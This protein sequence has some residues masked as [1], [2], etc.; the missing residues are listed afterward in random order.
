[1]KLKYYLRGLAVGVL[2]TTIILAIANRDNRP[3][4]DAQIRQ[5]ALELGMV[6]E[7]SIKLSYLQTG[8]GKN[9][10]ESL[11]PDNNPE[12]SV[13][14]SSVPESGEESSVEE[15]TE[16]SSASESGMESSEE[17]SSE[18]SS[19]PESSEENSTPD[20]QSVILQI[21]SGASSYTVS[22]DLAALGLVEDASAYDQFL[23]DNGYSK[24]IHVG[25]YEIM[26]G[27][28]EEDI[29]KLIAR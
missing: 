7:G 23:C 17:E 1:M 6:E 13:P 21:R 3:L 10:S 5:R 22:R 8:E 26:P 14:E 2:L 28:S 29:A 20:A 16:E 15:D 27:T 18:G 4:T 19:V 11:P 24:K 25:T 9:G 12:S